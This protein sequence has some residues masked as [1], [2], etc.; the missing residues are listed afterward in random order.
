MAQRIIVDKETAR[1]MDQ[2]LKRGYVA[3]NGNATR[4]LTR[5]IRRGGM[6]GMVD[7]GWD[8]ETKRVV[9]AM[10]REA[11]SVRRKFGFDKIQYTL[12]F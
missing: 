8:P 9:L 12:S 1:M 11:K 4:P 2:L 6:R 7:I 3:H 10:Q 5:A